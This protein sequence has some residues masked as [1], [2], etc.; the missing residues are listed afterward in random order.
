MVYDISPIIYHLQFITRLLM[1]CFYLILAA[2]S[3]SFLIY[4]TQCDLQNKERVVIL[5]IIVTVILFGA[6][7]DSFRLPSTRIR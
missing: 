2:F 1:F 6:L 3:L 5:N 4:I 7:V